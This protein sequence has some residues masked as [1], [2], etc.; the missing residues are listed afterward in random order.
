MNTQ[1]GLNLT[2]F[3]I[4]WGLTGGVIGTYVGSLIFGKGRVGYKEALVGTISG[5]IIMGSGS[6]I[7]D[8]IGIVIMIGAIAGLF[9]G[10][11]MR[12]LHPR[13]N[14]NTIYDYLGLFGPFF[15]SA[16]LGAFV[17][18]PA[19]LIRYHKHG[20]IPQ[21]IGVSYYYSLAGWQLVYVGISLGIG[22]GSGLF[23]GLLGC[24]DRD[25]FGLA[26]NS[27]IYENDFGLYTP[28]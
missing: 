17:V 19:A 16:F 27:R 21:S 23:V 11:Y 28:I 4:I 24:C 1:Y 15:I 10:F 9:S 26:S 12:V 8:S 22:I 6:A 2:Q 20:I 5:G 14:R 7:I 13:I 25:Y 3:N 18:A